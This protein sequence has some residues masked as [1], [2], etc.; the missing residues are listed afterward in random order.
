M[1]FDMRGN[2]RELTYLNLTQ[3]K[4]LGYLE[5]TYPQGMS[6]LGLSGPPK[7]IKWE[8]VAPFE[9]WAMQ[10]H[11]QSYVT[12]NRRGGCTLKEIIAIVFS[13]DSTELR[14]YTDESFLRFLKDNEFLAD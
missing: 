4:R 8:V 2:D 9:L 1:S 6:I 11:G 7:H 10:R 5:R 12:L 14:N 3:E 13:I